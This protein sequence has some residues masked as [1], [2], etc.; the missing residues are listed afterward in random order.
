MARWEHV[1]LETGEWFIPRENTKGKQSNFVVYLSPFANTQFNALKAVT[2]KTEWCFPGLGK[3]GH[4]DAR[5]ISKQVGDRQ[6]CFKKSRGG[7]PRKQMSNRSF[8][9][10]LVL[11]GG[12][13]GAWTP[14]DLRRTGATMMQALG[15]SLEV[16]DRCQNHVL[17]GSKVRRHY[18]HHDYA[19][20]K[21]AAWRLLGSNLA[22]I[23]AVGSTVE[24]PA[25]VRG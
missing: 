7:T 2:G 1:D 6:A 19:T 17:A 21:A 5:S 23:L 16:I 3:H 8:D 14:H 11:A 20:E 13:R 9:N 24:N 25:G 10:N 18:L 15:V 22:A 12:S 4:V